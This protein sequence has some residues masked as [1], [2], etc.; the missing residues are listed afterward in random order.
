MCSCDTCVGRQKKIIHFFFVASFP[1]VLKLAGAGAV[2]FHFPKNVVLTT[3]CLCSFL[4][5]FFSIP[6]QSSSCITRSLPNFPSFSVAP[7]N[8]RPPPTAKV[9]KLP[10]SRTHLVQTRHAVLGTKPSRV[11]SCTVL[12]SAVVDVSAQTTR[13]LFTVNPS[14]RVSTSSRCVATF[15]PSQRS[16][17]TQ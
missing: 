11:T 17:L 2:C 12:P 5:L 14:T 8:N 10:S 13:V 9:P 7:H 3:F 6:I 16:A 4:V 15:V 1:P